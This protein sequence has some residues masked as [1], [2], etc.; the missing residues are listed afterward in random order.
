MKRRQNFW[1]TLRSMEMLFFYCQHFPS[2][3]TRPLLLKYTTLWKS[4]KQPKGQYFFTPLIWKVLPSSGELRVWRPTGCHLV[5]WSLVLLLSCVRMWSST[6]S[7][8][9]QNPQRKCPSATTIM[10][11]S[12]LNQVSTQC[13]KNTTRSFSFTAKAFWSCSLVNVNQTEK[14]G[15]ILTTWN[16]FIS[17]MC[18]GRTCFTK[19]EFVLP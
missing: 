13:P 17:L 3:A 18:Q 2:E 19:C 5:L 6:A 4:P 11:T 14:V 12:C 8:L 1:K 10:T 7:G 16:V 9:S 15:P